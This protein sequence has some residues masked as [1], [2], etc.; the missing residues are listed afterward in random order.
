MDVNKITKEQF[1]AAYAKHPETKFLKFMY[2]YYN[3]KLKR[4]PAPIGTWTAVIA[5]II[6]TIGLIVFD[7]LGMKEV[8]TAFLWVYI[9]F[10]TLIFTLPAFLMN[11]SRTKKIAKELGVTFDQY[12]YLVDKYYS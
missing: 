8:A 9:P 11:K 1:D 10:G 2:T 3:V 5:W 7:Q 12:N 4:K 6:A